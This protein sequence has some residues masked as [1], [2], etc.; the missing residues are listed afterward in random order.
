M[1]ER[2]R[3]TRLTLSA[4]NA[5]DWCHNSAAEQTGHGE[6]HSCEQMGRLSNGTGNQIPY[7]RP[8]TLSSDSVPDYLNCL[9]NGF[10]VRAPLED[11]KSLP[12][13]SCA[14]RASFPGLAPELGARSLFWFCFQNFK[15]C[16]IWCGCPQVDTG[17]HGHPGR[18]RRAKK[19]P[20]FLHH[21]LGP[22]APKM[23]CPSLV[24]WMSLGAPWPEH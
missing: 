2:W 3:S 9:Q 19:G 5:A 15:P 11:K 22:R 23:F 6:G 13:L 10:C 1:S 16:F 4:N 18:A 21:W 8:Q 24:L 12:K 20:R 14:P 7:R 17:L